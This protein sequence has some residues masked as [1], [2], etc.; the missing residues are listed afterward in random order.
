MKPC[1]DCGE[2]ATKVWAFTYPDQ[3]IV[4]E[5]C[6]DNRRLACPHPRWMR[7]LPHP[8]VCVKC[9]TESLT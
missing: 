5:G 8:D 3:A 6:H 2:A 1:E 7:N 4:C 9:G